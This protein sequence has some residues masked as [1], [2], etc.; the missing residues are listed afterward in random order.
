MKAFAVQNSITMSSSSELTPSSNRF[1]KPTMIAL[2]FS[3]LF[4][5]LVFHSPAFAQEPAASYA[6]NT[7]PGAGTAKNQG[8]LPP[9]V[10]PQA[11]SRDRITILPASL[12]ASTAAL[13]APLLPSPPPAPAPSPDKAPTEYRSI[14]VS[15]SPAITKTPLAQTTDIPELPA[16][17]S[18]PSP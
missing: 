11:P 5:S 6:T 9:A 7:A 4:T 3:L 17:P 15:P 18:P 8:T 16:A 2:G 12:M 10:T 1:L 13:P 14:T